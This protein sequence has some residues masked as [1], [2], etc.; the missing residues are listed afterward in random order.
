MIIVN[1]D[2]ISG[3]NLSTLGL[4][5]GAIVQSKHVGRDIMAGLKSLVG[6]E[7]KGYTE[8]LNEA[9][10]I[11]TDRMIA[12]AEA[13]CADGIINIRFATSTIM[14]GASEIMAYGTAVK[15]L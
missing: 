6:G 11:A 12:E 4:V 9:R 13:L 2:Y 5:K 10:S 8:M 1:T 7:L 3:K 15:F 14:Q